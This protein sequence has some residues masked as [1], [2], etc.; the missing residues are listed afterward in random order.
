MPE[1]FVEI[2]REDARE[3]GVSDG[4]RVKVSSRRGELILKAAIRGRG[5]PP[6]GSVFVPFFDE[7]YLINLLTLDAHCPISKQPDYK[8][9]A[10][11]L[12][13]A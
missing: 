13:K 11:R 3:M 10:V 4:A 12:E 1:A 6:R 9:C 7:A 2:N 8:K 5:E